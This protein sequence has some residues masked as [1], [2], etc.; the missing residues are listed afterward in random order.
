MLIASNYESNNTKTAYIKFDASRVLGKTI[1]KAT[2]Q[3]TTNLSRDVQKQIRIVSDTSW[4]ENAL[5]YSNKPTMGEI[6]GVINLGKNDLKVDAPISIP[7]NTSKIELAPNGV[8][9]FGI[10]NTSSLSSTFSVYSEEVQNESFK[11]K[12]IIETY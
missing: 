12:L 1:K 2:L 10:D 5:S 6:V 3:L 11:P 4:N 8:I 9:A 7:L